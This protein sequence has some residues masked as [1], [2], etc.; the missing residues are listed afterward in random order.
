MSTYASRYGKQWLLNNDICLKSP[1]D[2][3]L[4]TVTSEG[5]LQTMHKVLKDH[6]L[7][8]LNME[9]LDIDHTI[10]ERKKVEKIVGWA[11]NHY[12][13][14]CPLTLVNEEKLHIPYES[15]KLMISRFME[16]EDP[17]REWIA[18]K[19]VRSEDTGLKFDG[20]GVLE[21]VR[22]VL[23]KTV[24]LPMRILEP[25]YRG[26]TLRFC[27]GILLF[28]PAGTGKPFVAKALAAESGANFIN[29]TAADF[30]SLVGEIFEVSEL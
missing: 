7:S 20:V 24:I 12:L 16:E 9:H 5:N 21:N 26:N 13:T 17:Q 14:S 15:I 3:D 23:Y 2:K 10:M 6:N 19:V 18:S 8:C 28:G 4:K 1:K 11:V 29:I 25:F 22:K 27:K 30:T